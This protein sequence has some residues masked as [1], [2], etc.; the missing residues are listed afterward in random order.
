MSPPDRVRATYLNTFGERPTVVARAPGRVN[1][2]GEHV[3]YGDGWVLP[4]AIDRETVVCAGPGSEDRFEVV[5]ADFGDE[6]DQFSTKADRIVPIGHPKWANH[7]RGVAHA[8]A[9]RGVA[10]PP[11]RLALGGTVPQG[12]GLSSSASLAVAVAAALARLAGADL[13]TTE[14]ALAAQ[15]SEVE[16]VG[17]NCGIMDQLVVARAEAGA[18][19]LIDCR[20]LATTPVPVPGDWAVLIVESGIERRLAEG[21]YNDRRREVEA[22]ARHYGVPTLRDLS[23]ERLKTDRGELDDTLFRRA[24]HQVTENARTLAAIEAL[25]EGELTAFGRLM[26]ASHASLRDDFAVSLP[27]IDGLVALLQDAIGEAGG[28]RMTG[29]GFG[30][31]VVAVL[32]RARLSA[33]RQAV[34]AGCRT[35]AG[36]PPATLESRPAGGL[37]VAAA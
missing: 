18:A 31:S 27:E 4:M 1:L 34:E 30:G 7:V 32:D 36:D 23:V 9:E 17:T 22:A 33:V 11:A 19:L 13:D 2:I 20:S 14:L 8:L 3:D 10:L 24:R 35:P 16:F 25:R 29:G 15:A 26:A 37:T 5:A 6:R 28:A 12:S 21:A